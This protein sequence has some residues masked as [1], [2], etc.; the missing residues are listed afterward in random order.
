MENILSKNVYLPSVFI[1]GFELLI[2]LVVLIPILLILNIVFNVND[3]DFFNFIIN[4]QYSYLFTMVVLMTRL[5]GVYYG[6]NYAYG[7]KKIVA[8]MIPLIALWYVIIHVILYSVSSLIL[9]P[10]SVLDFFVTLVIVTFAVWC[11]LLAKIFDTK[12]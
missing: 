3:G 5:L 10:S 2:S 11:F 12:I 6:V 4:D 7:K 9:G 8:K 1:I